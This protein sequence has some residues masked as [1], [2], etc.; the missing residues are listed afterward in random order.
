MRTLG[1][2]AVLSLGAMGAAHAIGT[3]VTVTLAPSATLPPLGTQP[4][5][6]ATNYNLLDFAYIAANNTTGA[7][8]E[9]GVLQ[10]TTFV[11][12]STALTST[13]SGLNNG[14]GPAAYGLYLMFNATAQ[15]DTGSAS[16]D[17]TG[18]FTSITY[19]LVGDPGNTD[20]ILDSGTAFSLQDNG[21]ADITLATGTLGTAALRNAQNRADTGLGIPTAG[22]L[23]T[24]G[25]TAEGDRYFAAPINLNLQE[26]A[27]TNTTSVITNTTSGNTT[28]I[29]INGG[30][31]NGTFLTT[32][33]PE[34]ASLLL[35][36]TGL[37][38]LGLSA[39]RKR[40]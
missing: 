13:Q 10:F 6:Q 9:N 38:G 14:T 36:G 7:A 33:V 18:H 40:G 39:R 15:T 37:L 22:V 12:G 16:G 35:L 4:N 11:N 20:K 30:G 19:S 34:P 5:F 8:T 3:P 17:S 26:D 27:F 25:K 24:L 2:V 31:G 29:R 23:L 21:T 1:A 32:P 28:T